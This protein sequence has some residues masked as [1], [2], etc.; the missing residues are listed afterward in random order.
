MK[1]L[2]F[3][4]VMSVIFFI[5]APIHSSYATVIVSFN[6]SDINVPVGSSFSVDVF[7]EIP[8]G[9]YFTNWGLIFDYND[10]LISLDSITMGETWGGDLFS[11][12]DACPACDVATGLMPGLPVN[13]DHI[14]ATLDFT[15][16]GEGITS[17]DISNSSY[18]Y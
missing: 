10:S 14:L 12:S 1:K 7:V 5:G 15:C 16:L 11:G 13:Y 6:P 18:F 9:E 3:I 4:T 8:E 2:S 17:L